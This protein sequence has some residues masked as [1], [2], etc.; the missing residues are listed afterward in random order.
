MTMQV[1]V[2]LTVQYQA[3][4]WSNSGKVVTSQNTVQNYLTKTGFT[5]TFG[6]WIAANSTLT[7]GSII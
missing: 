3:V 4:D 7:V 2:T 6:Q 1:P 5:G